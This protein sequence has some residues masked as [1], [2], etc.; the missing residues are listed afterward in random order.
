MPLVSVAHGFELFQKQVK[1]FHCPLIRGPVLDSFSLKSAW[2]GG[3]L[4]S[5]STD[6]ALSDIS[7]IHMFTIAVVVR[8]KPEV[9]QPEF[10]RIW[11]D[12]YGPMYRQMPQVKSYVQYH[13]ADRRKDA[14]EEPID[15]IAIMSFDSE[16]DM[17][18][19]WDTD[20]YREAAKVRESIMRET[21]VGVHVASV[22][23]LVRII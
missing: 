11:K 23:E 7:F 18:A 14:T 8:K 6:G 2:G 5:G 4:S 22:E 16:A 15:G 13:L 1:L 17:K 10:R 3:P 21:A 12:I 9:S 20:I 19:A